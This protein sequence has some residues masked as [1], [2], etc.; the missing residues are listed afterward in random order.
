MR[1]GARYCPNLGFAAAFL[2][3][4]TVWAR[5]RGCQYEVLYDLT[6]AYAV[7]QAVNCNNEVS[8]REALR[9]GSS[10]VL[11]HVFVSPIYW[12]PARLQE[13]CGLLL[14]N[15]MQELG[16]LQRGRQF[17]HLLRHLGGDV[18]LVGVLLCLVHVVAQNGPK[19]PVNAVEDLLVRRDS[20]LAAPCRRRLV[21]PRPPG[22]P[23]LERSIVRQV[24]RPLV[25]Q[26]GVDLKYAARV[27]CGMTQQR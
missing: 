17:V 15:L 1:G 27:L 19:E 20:T 25:E 3:F 11:F 7:R 21:A 9:L 24:T 16:A 2:S 12:C 14:A 10:T 18:Q 22:T 4:L 13:R 5:I 8:S 6:V 23:G 26:L